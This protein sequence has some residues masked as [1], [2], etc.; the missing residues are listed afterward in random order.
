VNTDDRQTRKRSIVDI[1]IG[2]DEFYGVLD[3]WRSEFEAAI[4]SMKET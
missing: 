4:A 1:S 3:R 2:A